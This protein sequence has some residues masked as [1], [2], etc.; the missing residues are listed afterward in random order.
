MSL[1]KIGHRSATMGQANGG[2]EQPG[3]PGS[4]RFALFY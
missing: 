4:R 3:I 1:Q 2:E